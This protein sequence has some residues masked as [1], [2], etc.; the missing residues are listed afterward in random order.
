[1]FS[2]QVGAD[3]ARRSGGAVVVRALPGAV[4]ALSEDSVHV[5]TIG[6]VGVGAIGLVD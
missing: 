1:M 5:G 2:V 6:L 3:I 4:R